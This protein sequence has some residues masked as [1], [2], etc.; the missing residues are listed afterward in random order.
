MSCPVSV[1]LTSRSPT[2]VDGLT[3]QVGKPL[4]GRENQAEHRP[5]RASVE[6]VC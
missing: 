4:V 1:G 2:G 5:N 6:G 3:G